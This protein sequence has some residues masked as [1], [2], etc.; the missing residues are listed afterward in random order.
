V[1]A[2]VLEHRLQQAA[3]LQAVQKRVESSRSDAIPVM[4]Q[5]FHHRQPKDGFV[6]RMDQHMNSYQAEKE[7]SLMLGHGSN[8]PL[9]QPESNTDSVLSK[10]DNSSA[11][12]P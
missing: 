10:V 5:F 6:G 7:F 9:L 11:P 1:P 4:P 2:N 3:A 12:Q 8:I